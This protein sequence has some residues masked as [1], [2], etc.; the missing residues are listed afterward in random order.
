[1]IVLPSGARIWLACGYTDMRKGMD[2]LAMLAQQVL[3]EDPFD[4]A[5]FAYV[6]GTDPEVILLLDGISALLGDTSGHQRKRSRL[7]VSTASCPTR[8]AICRCPKRQRRTILASQRR[9]E[10]RL[11][12]LDV[13]GRCVALRV[14]NAACQTARQPA[15]RVGVTMRKT[16]HEAPSLLR[17]SPQDHMKIGLDLKGFVRGLDPPMPTFRLPAE[18]QPDVMPC[19][20]SLPS[21][22]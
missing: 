7:A 1:M 4:G 20:L 16:T 12:A 17:R 18:Q 6:Q 19:I 13:L 10:Q 9:R 2:G 21:G 5:L 11:R 22:P 15:L 8:S 14:E 3:Q